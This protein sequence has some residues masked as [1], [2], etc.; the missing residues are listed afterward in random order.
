MD[1][2][3]GAEVFENEFIVALTAN[4]AIG[5]FDTDAVK[6]AAWSRVVE[7]AEQ[8]YAPCSFTS[9]VGW[10]WTSTPSG[11][12]LHRV[13][14]TPAGRKE[15][16][17]ILPFSSLDS[18]KPED[19]WAWLSETSHQTGAEFLAIPHNSNLSGGMMFDEVDSEGRPIDAAYARTRMRCEPVVVVTRFDVCVM[20]MR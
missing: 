19:L 17:N 7:S 8:H 4:E 9:F 5:D 18:D 20:A 1:E 6:R 3:K 13:V 2:G 10:E 11:K 12:N 15:V 16:R 14:L